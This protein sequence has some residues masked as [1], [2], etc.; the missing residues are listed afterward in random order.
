MTRPTS[1][2]WPRP[3]RPGFSLATEV[4]EWL[5]RS[6]VPFRDAHEITGQLVACTATS[7][8]CELDEVYRRRPGRGHRRTSRP[9]S[10]TV[11]DGP[12]GARR[13]HDATAAPR[14]VRVADQLAAARRRR[15]RARGLGDRSSADR[16]ADPGLLRRPGPRGRAGPARLRVR[17]VS[18]P[19]VT[20]RLTEVEAYAGERRPRLARLP[21]PHAAQRGDVRPARAR[22]T[23]TSPTACTG[24]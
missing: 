8:D 11:L 21:R 13:P 18:R 23:S 17:H 14:P 22:S 6:G 5:V 20:V 7:T 10:A 9:R 15:A 3:R 16:A 1:T 4:A 19:A 12:R 2:G 24:A